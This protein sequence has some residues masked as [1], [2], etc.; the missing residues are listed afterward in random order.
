MSKS[1]ALY[2]ALRK[3]DASQPLRVGW[4]DVVERVL[5]EH[6]YYL[7]PIQRAADHPTARTTD[8]R[9]SNG[10]HT[11]TMRS[12]SQRHRLLKAYDTAARASLGINGLDGLTDEEAME[13]AE[14]VRHDS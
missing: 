1:D 3:V 12:G 5:A 14:G 8:P 7:A 6:G 4:F 11:Y 9:T 13:H 10:N 2:E